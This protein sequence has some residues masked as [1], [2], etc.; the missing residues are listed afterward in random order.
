[1]IGWK[2]QHPQTEG[3][4]LKKTTRP[5]DLQREDLSKMAILNYL[6]QQ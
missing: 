3:V 6:G 2:L 5:T 4:V 1:M